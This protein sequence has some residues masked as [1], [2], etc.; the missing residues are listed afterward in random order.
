MTTR[1]NSAN[2]HDAVAAADPRRHI[3]AIIMP[4][5]KRARSRLRHDGRSR[6]AAN[7]ASTIGK[8]LLTSARPAAGG[9]SRPIRQISRAK[10]RSRRPQAP[11]RWRDLYLP[12]AS[13]RS[14]RS[15]PEAAR[16]AA[17]RWSP[18]SRPLDTPPNPEL[19]DMT[20]R[21]WIGLVLTL[22]VFVLEMGGHLVG[23]HGC[24]D[25]TLSNWI[26]LVFATPVV[27]W[28]GWPFFVRGWQSLLTRN[29]NMF[30]LIAMGT[31]VAYALQPGR[32]RRARAF[33][34]GLPRPWRRGRGLFRGRRRDH[35]AGPA[36]PGAGAARPRSTPPAPSRRC[37]DWRRRPRAASAT[38]APTMRSRSTAS[39]SATPARPARRKG[40]GRRRH[41]RRPLLAR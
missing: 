35:R 8:K 29:L 1:P 38:T 36:R 3:T 24:V 13:A 27:I 37:C 14:G 11:C 30:T 7:I 2:R 40:A 28:A 23:S 16:S 9:N 15:V 10:K 25:Q 4:T 39:R 41:S 12:D 34:G 18:R 31:G 19:A 32:H 5:A 33:P 26:Q 21:F 20:R 17:W 6:T 22:P